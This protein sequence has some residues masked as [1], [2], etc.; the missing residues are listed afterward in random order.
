[1]DKQQAK[2]ALGLEEGETNY[3][4]VYSKR[5]AQILDLLNSASTEDLKATYQNILDE[6]DQAL[7][8]LTEQ[9][10]QASHQSHPQTS[11]SPDAVP[12]DTQQSTAG[13]VQPNSFS[14]A[15]GQTLAGRYEIKEL[16]GQGGMAVV[17]RAYDQNISEDIAI[18]VLFP[19]LLSNETAIERFLTEA[20][21][22]IRLSHPNIVNVFDV[23]S[24]GDYYFLTMELLEGQTLRSLLDGL[25]AA[26]QTMTMDETMDI[27]S[28]LSAALEE[29]HQQTVHYAIKPENVWI[30]PD[31]NI[32]LLDFGISRL[33]RTSQMTQSAA[34][35]GTAYYMAPEQIRGAKNIDARADQ[36]ALAV[37]IYEMLS[38]EMPARRIEPL[39]SLNR[40]VSQ[41]FSKVIEKALNS[42]AEGRFASITEF[43]QSLSS[44]K[45][46]NPLISLLNPKAIGIVATLLIGIVLGATLGSS[47]GP[48]EL[49]DK[50]RPVS[51][52]EKQQYSE[53]NQLEGE[54]KGLVRR[55]S[56]AK[57][58]LESNIKEGESNI[59]RLETAR[60]SA[61]SEPGK[62]MLKTELEQAQFDH[63][64]NQQLQTLTNQV[65]YDDNGMLELE[66]TLQV[67]LA[68]IRDKQYLPALDSLRPIRQSLSNRLSQFSQ[69]EEYLRSRENLR[70]AKRQWQA[71]NQQ[72]KLLRP[73]IIVAREEGIASAERLA[74]Q[75]ELKTATEQIKTHTQAY[76]QDYQS[77]IKLVAE[78]EQQ[79][80]QQSK[81]KNLEEQWRAYLQWP[82]YLDKPGFKITSE[83]SSA[84]EQLKTEEKNYLA[85]QAFAQAE[86][87]SKALGIVLTGYFDDAKAL[88]EINEKKE[89]A[90]TAEKLEANY[91]KEMQVGKT[92]LNGKFYPI[93]MKH[94]Q[95]ALNYKTN[96]KEA[97][98][99]YELAK[100]SQQKKEVEANYQAAMTAGRAEINRG[101]YN[102]SLE[103]FKEALRIKASDKEAL[104]QY[105]SAIKER[106][107]ALLSKY[108]PG[109]TL[110]EIPSGNFHMGDLTGT[111]DS[112]EKPVHQ[113]K[114]N[115]FKLMK[116]EVTFAQYDLYADAT[117]QSKPSD[118]IWGRANRPVINVN[119]NQAEAYAKWLSQTTGLKF[120]L[121]SEAEW[122]YAARGGTTAAYSWGNPIGSNLVGINNANCD[123]CGSEWDGT[124]TAPVGS[125]KANPFGLKDM[126]GNV[127]EWV[128]D[129]WNDSYLGAPDNGNAWQ[130]GDCSRR[131]LRGG[132][133]NYS[134]KSMR[135]ATR[136]WYSSDG[137]G[138]SFGFRLALDP[139]AK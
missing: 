112:S 79:R 55:L 62:N 52:E 114:L 39:D 11:G 120:R 42:K 113:V 94:F 26:G 88:A 81:T 74:G 103:F 105:D 132:S 56:Q 17:F 20:K 84:I 37:M 24:D 96:D 128:Q 115:G 75:G 69:S 102:T 108:A 104:R 68:L 28:A 71:H 76:Q 99:Q 66:G 30:T 134:P 127:W 130:S 23:Q 58:K 70:F 22:S 40:E 72:Q 15:P 18:K 65:I 119:W 111:V 63:H 10:P 36:Y 4:V 118:I 110:V 107:A 98:R 77:D 87:T 54:V 100:S 14:L 138:S 32:K 80:S 8:I 3:Q 49:W 45:T 125:F 89:A 116:H 34:A 48:A 6:I 101:S 50:I 133:W 85:I 27:V 92:A 46:A 90:A 97:T 53:A 73:K 67:S 83:Q 109:M 21:L 25:K 91:L 137:R 123:G 60:K 139:Q 82:I 1:M 47:G 126:H 29:A 16:M 38:G 41:S 43:H 86:A 95:Q 57:N 44:N 9:S 135:S 78:R 64:H 7:A 61:T 136:G 124:K 129:C 122:E 51:A 117:G 5:K 59:R 33:M 13:E 121:P 93:A 31:N 131:V 35:M 12:S 106:D 2:N 19:G